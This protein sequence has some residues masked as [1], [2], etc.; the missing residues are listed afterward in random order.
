M[1]ECACGSCDTEELT[2]YREFIYRDHVLTVECVHTECYTCGSEFA[3]WFQ[4]NRNA[5]RISIAKFKIDQ[6]I[7][8][9]PETE[10]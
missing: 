7:L 8:E 2:E 4:V 5:S 3:T 6:Y 9:N 10:E 1:S